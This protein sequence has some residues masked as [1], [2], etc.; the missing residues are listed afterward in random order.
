MLTWFRLQKCGNPASI[1]KPRAGWGFVFLLEL[2]PVSVD[3]LNELTL[4][5]LIEFGSHETDMYLHR[6]GEWVGVDVPHML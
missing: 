2:I 1:K 5:A 4:E 6:I 3:C